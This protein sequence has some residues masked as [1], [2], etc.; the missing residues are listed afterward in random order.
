M[1][2]FLRSIWKS[3]P[4][5]KRPTWEK[6]C[7]GVGERRIQIIRKKDLADKVLDRKKEKE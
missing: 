4:P 5:E 6:F 2:Q 1:R 3:Q 7:E